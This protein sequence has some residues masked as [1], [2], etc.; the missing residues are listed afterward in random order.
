MITFKLISIG[1]KQNLG[2]RCSKFYSRGQ[3]KNLY[4]IFGFWPSQ[5]VHLNPLGQLQSH[6]YMCVCVCENYTTN[7]DCIYCQ[8][9]SMKTKF[10]LGFFI[11]IDYISCF[12]QYTCFKLYKKYIYIY[13]YN[14]IPNTRKHSQAHFQS[15]YQTSENEIVFKKIFFEK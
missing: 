15:R 2:S 4:I 10:I 13:I 6:L 8:N 1:I 14:F 12:T 9:F 3:K 7:F 11:Y 5:G